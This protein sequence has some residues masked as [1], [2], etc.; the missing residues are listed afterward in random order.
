MLDFERLKIQIANMTHTH[1]QSEQATI[2]RL[3]LVLLLTTTLR[4]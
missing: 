3:R 1:D 4:L 2:Q